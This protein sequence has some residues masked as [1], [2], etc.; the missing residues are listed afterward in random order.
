MEAASFPRRRR[1]ITP[2]WK[3]GMALVLY[4]A[5]LFVAWQLVQET[6]TPSTVAKPEPTTVAPPSTGPLAPTSSD[7]A[8]GT[9]ATRGGRSVVS[10]GDAA[11]F[12]A[13]T[14][15]GLSLVVTAR[16]AGG[17][18]TGPDRAVSVG[19]GSRE[20]DGKLVRTNRRSGLGLVRVDGDVARPLWQQ[21]RAAPVQKGD[22]LVAVTP[23]GSAVFVVTESR[24]SAIWGL[25]GRPVP[26]A[27]VFDESGRLVGVTT[28]SRIIPIDRACGSIRRC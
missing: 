21:R 11:G 2:S 6:R 5:A 26:G 23:A 8:L 9:I 4:A 20:L 28:T 19:L 1:R 10:I 24:H 12:V 14:A 27:P 7:L 25:R 3:A 13:W 22:R 17:W 15:N 16:P 18:Q